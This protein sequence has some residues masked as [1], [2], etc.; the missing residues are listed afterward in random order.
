MAG[1]WTYSQNQWRN[2][3]KGS[4]RKAMKLSI[5]HDGKLYAATVSFP[6]DT[7]YAMMYTRYH[8]Q[9]LLFIIAYNTWIAAGGLLS[10]DTMTLQELFAAMK[11]LLDVW[12]GTTVG[13]YVKT[14]TDRKSVV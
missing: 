3:T 8:A 4:I 6:L 14:S 5:Y 9:H 7:D 10:G 1:L 13:F 12:I 2:K 11:V